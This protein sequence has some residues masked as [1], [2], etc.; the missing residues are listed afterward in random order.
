MPTRR[1]QRLQRSHGSAVQGNGGIPRTQAESGPP[2]PAEGAESRTQTP[3]NVNVQTLTDS[4]TLNPIVAADTGP[5]VPDPVLGGALQR[6]DMAVAGGS[7]QQRSQALLFPPA[8]NRFPQGTPGTSRT[9][10]NQPGL[11]PV[12]STSFQLPNRGGRLPVLCRLPE[13]SFPI[14]CDNPYIGYLFHSILF[15]FNII[16]EECTTMSTQT[17]KNTVNKAVQTDRDRA[18]E[19]GDKMLKEHT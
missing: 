11:V 19:I 14:N 7:S 5:P 10:V 9:P 15:P 12:Y 6:H 17:Q 1:S 16:T 13:D 18:M 2:N 4:P 8:E 3:V